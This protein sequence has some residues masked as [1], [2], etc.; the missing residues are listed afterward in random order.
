MIARQIEALRHEIGN[1]VVGVIGHAPGAVVVDNGDDVCR[2]SHGC[3]PRAFCFL[4]ALEPPR[5]ILL[6]LR[7]RYWPRLG[8]CRPSLLNGKLH[9]AF[10][11]AAVVIMHNI[12]KEF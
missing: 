4:K 2:G 5:I 9:I 6:A 10:S 1:D 7:G 8:E 12:E 11:S 3:K